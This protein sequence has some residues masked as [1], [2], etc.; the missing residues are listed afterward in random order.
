MADANPN[1]PPAPKPIV[2]SIS[3]RM[4]RNV[5]FNSICLAATLLALMILFVLLAS[6]LTQG[7]GSLSFRFITSLNSSDPH[8]AGIWTSLF[9]TLVI[10]LICALS[11]IPLGVGTAILIE[12]FK[13]K[14]NTEEINRVV[15]WMSI[16]LPISIAIFAI[17]LWKKSVGTDQE[18][19]VYPITLIRAMAFCLTVGKCFLI[20][21]LINYFSKKAAIIISVASII[22]VGIFVFLL[23][24]LSGHYPV[25]F[26]LLYGL[27]IFYAAAG[28]FY[29]SIHLFS[30][31]SPL[32]VL[33]GIID[34]NIRNLAGVPSIV[35]GIL[36]VTAF[37]TMFGMFGNMNSGGFA[38][39][40][41]WYDQYQGEDKKLYYT[42]ADGP[43]VEGEAGKP[44]EQG[45]TLYLPKQGGMGIGE[46]ATDLEWV[47]AEDIEPRVE[48]IEDELDAFEDVFRDGIKEARESRR[49]PVAVDDA[50][51]E[52][53]VDAAI[54]AGTWKNPDTTVLR[55]KLIGLVLGL[56]GK[57]GGDLIK[58][59]AIAIDIAI[60]SEYA[61]RM[62]NVI[63][64]GATPVRVNTKAW[65]HL[66]L[67][68][69]RGVLA[70]GLTLMLV[71]LP[72]VIVASQEALRAVPGSYRQGALALGSTKWQSVS[73]TALPAAIP[74]ICT[75]TI[76][77]LSRAIGEAAPILVLGGTGFITSPPRNLMDSF[78]A[79]PMT[80]FQWTKEPEAEYKTIA[81]AGII[82]LLIV[83]LSFNAIAIYI[84]QRATK[85][86]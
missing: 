72:I 10:C 69:G 24:L 79:L 7:V 34:T 76:L 16:V 36:G 50:K 85:H 47:T 54:E 9:G 65:Y 17:W 82:V 23:M 27:A 5:V 13:P 28:A 38:I 66:A 12:E 55:E 84:R 59:R 74:G 68:F 44:A 42:R 58:A 73:K 60:D 25:L 77:A 46:V 26:V 83:L 32:I 53:I 81:A 41:T 18:G 75:G 52:A 39:G 48:A 8:K 64:T 1:N 86:Q 21:A 20:Y 70:G 22:P 43:P 40:Q 2:R 15:K 80:I 78:S 6:I 67:P 61:A 63:T 4:R 45:M 19:D 57:K 56:D 37:A 62:P 3:N 29:Y 30:N 11:A 35:Y 51:A 49:G 71:I 31:G 14:G 33:H